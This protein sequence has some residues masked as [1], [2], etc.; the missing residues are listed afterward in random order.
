MREVGVAEQSAQCP[1]QP[2]DPEGGAT[3]AGAEGAALQE[4]ALSRVPEHASKQQVPSAEPGEQKQHGPA[5]LP[6]GQASRRLRARDVVLLLA[7]FAGALL[8]LL[9]GI[10]KHAPYWLFDGLTFLVTFSLACYVFFNIRA[11]AVSQA[12]VRKVQG[13]IW[14][15]AIFYM[16]VECGFLIAAVVLLHRTMNPF[17]AEYPRKGSAFVWCSVSSIA[18]N[19]YVVAVFH[20]REKSAPDTGVSSAE[21]GPDHGHLQSPP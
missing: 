4:Q 2:S 14:R 9:G 10:T 18:I 5:C 16:I 12:R 20:N 7:T 1:S 15:A 21:A 6:E 13:A 11:D 3:D 19:L 17:S 8:F